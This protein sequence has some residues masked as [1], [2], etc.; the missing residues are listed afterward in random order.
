MNYFHY[1]HNLEINRFVNKNKFGHRTWIRIRIVPIFVLDILIS[2]LL[3]ILARDVSV[4]KINYYSEYKV[5]LEKNVV[6]HLL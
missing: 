4:W 2:I 6:E 5:V 3:L 1:P